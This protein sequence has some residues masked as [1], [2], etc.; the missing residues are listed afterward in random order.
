[1]ICRKSK[2]YYQY[3]VNSRYLSKKNDKKLIC[4]LA[5]EEYHIK[6]LSVIEEE[7][8][9]LK[10]LYK[11]EEQLS[12]VYYRIHEGKQILFEPEIKPVRK[13]IEE[14]EKTTYKGLE[15]DENNRS[16]YITNKGERVRSKSEKIIADALE[17]MQIP[18]KYEKPLV[19]LVNGQDKVFYPDFTVLNKTTGEVKYLEHLGMMDNENYYKNVLSKLDV[20]EKNGLLIGRDLLLLHESSYQPLNTRVVTD[21]I[22]EFLV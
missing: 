3:Y 14:F 10:R 19:L 6:L 7:L 2:G 18:Y 16:E 13:Q 15:F 12:E 21:Y 9:N 22:D 4:K 1:M 11:N 20:Y 8:A 17:R 5:K